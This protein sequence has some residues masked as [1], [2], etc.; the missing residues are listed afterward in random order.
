M[1]TEAATVV[2]GID[3]ETSGVRAVAAD[4]AGTVVAKA[5]C[6]SFSDRGVRE[7]THEQNPWNGAGTPSSSEE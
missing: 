4:A 6:P 1:A 5:A 3:V 2:I 7:A